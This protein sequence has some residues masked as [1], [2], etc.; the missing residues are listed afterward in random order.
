M[1]SL[2]PPKNNINSQI[3]FD[4]KLNDSIHAIVRINDKLKLK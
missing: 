2:K 3:I 1:F 4:Q